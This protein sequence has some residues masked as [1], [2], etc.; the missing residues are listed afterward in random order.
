MPTER[1]ILL[2]GG[3]T[4]ASELA[5]RLSSD[6]HMWV[7]M[8]LAGRTVA[9]RTSVAQLRVGGFG[10]VAGLVAY[11]R[12]ERIDV[13]V[14]ATHPFAATMPFHAAAACAETG[15]GLLKLYRPAWH[16]TDG[17]RW[18]SVASLAAAACA[19]E[20]IGARRVL[21]TTGRTELDPFRRLSGMEFLVRSIEAP[22]LR[23]FASAQAV[24]DRGPFELEAERALLVDN[25]IDTLVSKNSGGRA[26]VAK[27]HAARELGVPVVMVERPP[28]PD[29]PRVETVDEA[30]R[31]I[32][33][34]QVG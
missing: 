22:D 13:L 26:A 25:A 16:A 7:T 30:E 10:G 14:D 11:L 29:F 4:E 2:L 20:Q 8:S 19:L 34:L 28:M 1:R 15:V 31:W 32:R 33:S 3:T 12:D 9:P 5:A 17:D 18:H 23:G 6:P 27:L 21:L 24:L